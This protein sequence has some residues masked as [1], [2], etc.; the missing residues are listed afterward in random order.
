MH[1]AHA[2]ERE[3]KTAKKQKQTTP[4][5]LI[6]VPQQIHPGAQVA[7]LDITSCLTWAPALPPAGHLDFKR[8]QN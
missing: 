8:S 6:S 1:A 2:K 5:N 3:G 4:S 7:S